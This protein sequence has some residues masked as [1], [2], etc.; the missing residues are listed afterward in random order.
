MDTGLK[1]TAGARGAVATGVAAELQ[2]VSG[3]MRWYLAHGIVTFGGS[4]VGR[5]RL[6]TPGDIDMVRRQLAAHNAR[7]AE[8]RHRAHGLFAGPTPG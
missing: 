2:G 5:T 7:A 4:K 3:D 6:W 1:R 8:R